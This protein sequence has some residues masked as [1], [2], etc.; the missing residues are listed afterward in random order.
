MLLR[1]ESLE[2]SMSQLGHSRRFEVISC[3]SASPPIADISLHR[4]KSRA[5]PS[6]DIREALRQRRTPSVGC[7]AVQLLPR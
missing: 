7:C 3:K 5:G 1:Y 2:P 6:A 4:T